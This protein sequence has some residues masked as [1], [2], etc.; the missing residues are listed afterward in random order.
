MIW[1]DGIN[2]TPPVLFTFNPAFQTAAEWQ[3]PVNGKQRTLTSNRRA[4]VEH[5][6][7]VMDSF[8]IGMDQVK[9]VRSEGTKYCA[10]KEDLVADY[11]N[12]YRFDFPRSTV[13]FRDAGVAFN[14]VA[15]RATCGRNIRKFVEYPPAVHHLLSPN[16]N[17][18]HGAAKAKWRAS[19]FYCQDDVTSSLYL[20][21][22]LTRASQG[23]VVKHF[24]RAYMLNPD[25]PPTLERCTNLF[26]PGQTAKVAQVEWLKSC[27]LVYTAFSA[28]RVVTRHSPAKVRHQHMECDLDGGFWDVSQ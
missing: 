13:M 27:R 10:E 16:D 4:Q 28:R 18:L 1:A 23:A 2:R 15:D 7:A 12:H 14:N 19:S 3:T 24:D 22:E 8:G 25:K 11:F 9:Y 6:E 21:S 26:S 20:L 5:L 17:N